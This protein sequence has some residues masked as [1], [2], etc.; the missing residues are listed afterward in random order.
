MKPYT[1]MRKIRESDL[2]PMT[3]AVA[4]AIGLRADQT[5]HSW[6]SYGRIA[7]DT[8]MGRTAAVRHVKALAESGWVMVINRS[9]K[10]GQQSNSY[11]LTNPVDNPLPSSTGERG[12]VAQGNGGSGRGDLPGGYHRGP[13]KKSPREEQPDEEQPARPHPHLGAVIGAIGKGM[14]MP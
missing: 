12:V 14:R 2:P 3:R 13:R 11:M 10:H 8:G 6:P 1:W 9:N 4:W 7:K 5:C